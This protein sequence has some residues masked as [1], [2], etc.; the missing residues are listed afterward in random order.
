MGASLG[1]ALGLPV[2]QALAVFA[3]LGLGMALP[4]LAA[5]AVPAVGAPAAAARR[6][7]GDLPRL[8]A[9]PMFATVV[10]LVWVLGQQSGIDGAGRCC[11]RCWRW[12]SEPGGGALRPEARRGARLG[13]RGHR[14]AGGRRVRLGRAAVAPAAAAAAPPPMPADAG[15]PGR[16]SRVSTLPR[17]G[18]TGV[19]R[20]HRRLV[21]HLPVQQEDHAGRRRG[22]GRLR[23]RTRSPLLRADWTRRDPAITAAL[24]RLGRNG[25]PVYVFY[26][27]ASAPAV[28]S[29]VPRVRGSPSRRSRP[30]MSEPLQ[31]SVMMRP[32]P[33]LPPPSG[34]GRRARRPPPSVGQPAPDFT[35][36]DASGKTVT[37]TDYKGKHVVLEWT[38]PGCPFVQKHYNSG[39]MPA[40]QKDAGPR[41]W[42]GWRS[43]PP[44]KAGDYQP[45]EAGGLD[46]GA[47]GAAPTATLMDE[48]G[49]AGQGLRR[50][51]HAAHVHRQSRRASWSTPAASTA[52]PRAQPADIEGRDQLRDRGAGPKPWPASR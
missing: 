30:S 28:L 3:A 41:A 51:H 2:A 8:M 38:N 6:L 43:T 22:A 9:F 16:R 52:W 4:Y 50:A 15:S 7:D 5:S 14:V 23:G 45:R 48:D 47:Q 21:R 33:C 27:G 44:A 13:H 39:N 17:R 20:L 11:W 46:E 32:S 1:A 49:K 19:R 24:A 42:S 18:P 40:T 34:A 10:W 25:V 36:K 29:E 26:D 31:E 35:L 12:R 37:L